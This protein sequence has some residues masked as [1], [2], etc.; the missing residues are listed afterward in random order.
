MET[1]V[2]SVRKGLTLL[3]SA[4]ILFMGVA[5]PVLER[6]EI[7]DGPVAESEHNP[8]TCPPAHD[9]T[10]CTQVGSELLAS[11]DRP[12]CGVISSMVGAANRPEIHRYGARTPQREN[13][14][15]APPRLA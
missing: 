13:P 3:I 7:V 5:V 9:H 15:R 8:A 2:D 4:L 1:C 10:L 6:A 11:G 14:S 12:S